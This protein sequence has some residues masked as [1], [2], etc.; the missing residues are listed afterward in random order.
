MFVGVASFYC[1]K[2]LETGYDS[3]GR[4]GFYSNIWR[5]YGVY[6]YKMWGDCGSGF[7]ATAL[8]CDLL[9]FKKLLLFWGVGVRFGLAL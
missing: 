7:S 2:L 4:V 3:F 8:S 1:L 6:L 5:V 9:S